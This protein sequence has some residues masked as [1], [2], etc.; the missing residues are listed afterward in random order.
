MEQT[1]L[2]ALDQLC[3]SPFNPRRTFSEAALQDLAETMKP[4]T[5]SVLQPI[6]VRHRPEGAVP[7]E[8]V[9]GHR[10][11]RAAR[12][13]GLADVPALVRDLTD[14]EVKRAQIVENLQREDV[15]AIEEADGLN[16]LRHEHGISIEALM[17]QTGKSRTYIFNRLKLATAH[18]VVRQAVRDGH[19]GADLAQEVARVPQLLQPQA[20]QDVTYPD[21][22]DGKT[23]RVGR[24][25]RE[26]RN[27][28]AQRYQLKLAG[29]PFDTMS[30]KLLPGVLAC[31][32]C[33]R[34]SRNEPTLADELGADVCTDPDC[35]EAKSAAHAAQ[36]VAAARKKG[37]PVVEGDA[38]KELLSGPWDTHPTGYVPLSATAFV[39]NEDEDNEADVSVAEALK[40]LGKK[41]PV[42]TLIVHPHKPGV[43]LECI[44][45]E[46]EQAL[47]AALGQ[48]DDEDDAPG[49]AQPA[50]PE[51]TPE[52]HA[53]WQGDAW[54]RVLLAIL[55]RV[56]VTPRDAAELRMVAERELECADDF[57][58]AEEV[59]GWQ[60][61]GDYA[62]R[63]QQR[64]AK[65]AAMSG[66][67]LAQLL[68]M[69]AI[70]H[71][72]PTIAP[73]GHQQG[74][75]HRCNHRLALAARYGV[76]V[77]NPA[78]TNQP[79]GQAA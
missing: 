57:G 55:R 28:L 15:S 75:E 43:V 63:Q 3:E 72:T 73:Y 31:D 32:A 38:A 22:R 20:L 12:I 11:V 49:P 34:N 44:T 64:Q 37:R 9:F 62:E 52:Q 26:A 18:E 2:I 67:E 39:D 60:V 5:G 51:L 40:R 59:L 77:M 46:Q 58:L 53:V 50:G 8:I 56:L 33:P 41:A 54:R 78:G 25:V 66:D 17:K 45:E 13:A 48:A 21:H 23:V 36:A 42:P 27:V 61:E 76:D 65:L 1:T 24:G 16:A 68:V 14:E 4:P 10:R 7:F 79:E 6:V 35:F 30:L 71:S 29:A 70:E 47:R 19:V 74:A 69:V